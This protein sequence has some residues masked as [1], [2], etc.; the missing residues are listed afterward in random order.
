MFRSRPSPLQLRGGGRGKSSTGD[1]FLKPDDEFTSSPN[2]Q[3]L[4]RQADSGDQTTVTTSGELDQRIR[5]SSGSRH[6][7]DSPKSSGASFLARFARKKST[8]NGAQS[9]RPSTVFS[10]ILVNKKLNESLK[11]QQQQQII[12][13]SPPLPTKFDL[14]DASSPGIIT[15]TTTTTSIQTKSSISRIR[16]NSETNSDH[17]SNGFSTA[18]NNNNSRRSSELSPLDERLRRRLSTGL[19]AN[20]LI[21]VLETPHK[22]DLLREYLQ[23]IHADESIL[24]WDSLL[25][26]YTEPDPNSRAKLALE[27]LE[28]YLLP[29]S[30][31]Q[32]N[33]SANTSNQMIKLYEEKDLENLS[34]VEIFDE[35]LDEVF[36]DLRMSSTFAQFCKDRE[37]KSSTD[38]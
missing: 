36:T 28:S 18:N 26:R 14:K 25:Q 5:A 4:L 9:P 37:G 21:T 23:V 19:I 33:L 16:Y 1:S 29:S 7:T 32:V 38:E 10:P 8:N 27:I 22:R 34:W 20:R 12:T 35:V 17:T 3:R 30:P 15:T 6:E 11:Q 31:K 24:L 13:S 2:E